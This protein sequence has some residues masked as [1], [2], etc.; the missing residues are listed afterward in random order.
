M[1]PSLPLRS[2]VGV[3]TPVA[4]APVA[5][6]P[7]HIA[8]SV[9]DGEGE[10]A[11]SASDHS[12]SVPARLP[13]E[14][15]SAAPSTSGNVLDAEPGGLSLGAFHATSSTL[16]EWAR[17][18]RLLSDSGSEAQGVGAGSACWDSKIVPL[19]YSHNTG[20]NGPEEFKLIVQHSSSL[21]RTSSRQVSLTKPIPRLLRFQVA[22]S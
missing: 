6:H 20:V 18:G 2:C 22:L 17:H 19:S 1:P 3:D 10:G 21:H 9:N 7:G 5:N 4:V 16:R 8:P 14:S 15:V 11:G 13:A 12:S